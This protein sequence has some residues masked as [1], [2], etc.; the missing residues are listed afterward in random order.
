MKPPTLKGKGKDWVFFEYDIFSLIY[1]L[2]LLGHKAWD[3][4]KKHCIVCH[5]LLVF[6]IYCNAVV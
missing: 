3:H 6:H 2:K 5:N 4:I 1:S